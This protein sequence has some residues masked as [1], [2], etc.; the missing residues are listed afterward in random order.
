[1]ADNVTFQDDTPA[2]PPDGTIAE[3]KDVGSGVQRQVVAHGAAGS[4]TFSDPAPT[5][6]ASQ[7][8]AADVTRKSVFIQNVGSVDV[9]LGASGVTTSTGILLAA[10]ASCTDRESTDAWYAVTASGTADLRVMVV[11]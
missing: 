5:S 10:G 6:S 4:K 1:M 3:S 11:D 2:T 8:V 9:Y 7:I